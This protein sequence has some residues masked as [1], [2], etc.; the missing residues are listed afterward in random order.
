MP[1]YNPQIHHRRSIRLKG[2]DYSQAGLYFITICVQNREH[3]FGKIV[4]GEMILN[5]AGKMVEKEWVDLKNRFP[6]I[7]LHEF[8]VMPN[9]FHGIIQIVDNIDTMGRIQIGQSGKPQSGRPRIGQPQGIAPTPRPVNTVGAIPC[10]CPVHGCPV[11]GSPVH[12]A[13]VDNGIATPKNKK[14]IGDIM[15]AFKSIATVLYIRGVK[16]L[17]WQPFNKKLW[18]RNYH[19]HIIRNN[20]EYQYIANYIVN[21]PANWQHD[22]FYKEEN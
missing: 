22:K 21:S 9:H 20:G 16:T 15:D 11:H 8:I 3:L 13:V 4:D 10:G 5:D 18:Q 12:T 1:K 6:N 17:D 2:Y 14:T 19:E 7:E